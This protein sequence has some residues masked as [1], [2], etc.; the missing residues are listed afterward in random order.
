MADPADLGNDRAQQQLDEAIE[1]HRR[2]AAIPA[3]DHPLC[4]D[5]DEPIPL[6]R[7]AVLLGVECCVDCQ[8]LREARR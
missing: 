1:A 8:S 5:C 7:R 2:K 3:I 4:L 6:K